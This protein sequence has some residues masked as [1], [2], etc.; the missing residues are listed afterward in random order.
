MATPIPIP[1]PVIQINKVLL[2]RGII[3]PICFARTARAGSATVARSPNTKP[4]VNTKAILLYF[5]NE[6]P[7]IRPIGSM[8]VSRPTR[9]IACPRTTQTYPIIIFK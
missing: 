3:P 6:P 4:K 1:V 8:L 5:A 7:T 9:N 2:T